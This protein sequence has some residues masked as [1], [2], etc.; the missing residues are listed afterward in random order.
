MQGPVVTMNIKTTARVPQNKGT[1]P[2]INL[3]VTVLKTVR[4]IS[5]LYGLCYN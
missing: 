2:E 3:Q 4:I 1:L 5:I